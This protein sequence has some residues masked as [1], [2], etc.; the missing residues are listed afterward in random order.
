MPALEDPLATKVAELL[1]AQFAADFTAEKMEVF[2]IDEASESETL[3]VG[4]VVDDTPDGER[5]ERGGTYQENVAIDV[6]FAKRLTEKTQAEVAA[7]AS[8]TSA[9]KDYLKAQAFED[10]EGVRWNAVGYVWKLRKDKSRLN[11]K[12]VNSEVAYTGSF[13]SV[14]SVAFSTV[15]D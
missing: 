10:S 1:N 12:I 11:R 13:F 7:L 5:I 3:F 8:K 6:I 9:V 4:V 15:S 14:L 2:D